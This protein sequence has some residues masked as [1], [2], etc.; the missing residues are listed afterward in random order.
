MLSSQPAFIGAPDEDRQVTL[1]R[2]QHEDPLPLALSRPL[3]Q[4]LARAL[5]RSR[6]V[7][8]PNPARPGAGPGDRRCGLVAG[9]ASR[10]QQEPA[11]PADAPGAVAA[12]AAGATVASLAIFLIW[13]SPPAGASVR[14]IPPS[15]I[16][17]RV[18]SMQLA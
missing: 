9:S 11:D 4:A 2:V 6:A 14:R 5:S 7:R 16:A 12:G 13:E 3:E 15:P 10:V 8:F 18:P 17:W 1:S